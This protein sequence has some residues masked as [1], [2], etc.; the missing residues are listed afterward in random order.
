MKYKF[1]ELVDIPN[2]QNLMEGLYIASD[3]PS[4]IF[5]DTGAGEKAVMANE[6]ITFGYAKPGH[7]LFPGRKHTGTLTIAPIGIDEGRI[8]F[9]DPQINYSWFEQKSI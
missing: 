3:I 8:P 5:S 4:G 7:L 9:D 6:T 2:L 1:S